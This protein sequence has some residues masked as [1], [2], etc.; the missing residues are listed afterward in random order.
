MYSH[1]LFRTLG[2]RSHHTV[3]PTSPSPSRRQLTFTLVVAGLCVT[4]AA[5][6]AY[7][8]YSM[9]KSR[10]SEDLKSIMALVDQ[11]HE[12]IETLLGEATVIGK[13][14]DRLEAWND[15]FAGQKWVRE[16]VSEWNELQ[17]QRKERSDRDNTVGVAW[18]HLLGVGWVC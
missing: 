18:C 17:K 15:F 2:R 1:T 13:R 9:S 14:V 11:N 5:N 6:T 16:K 12:E 10:S 8:V 7:S 3:H 4:S